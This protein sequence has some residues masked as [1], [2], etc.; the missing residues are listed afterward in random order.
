MHIKI[1]QPQL[2]SARTAPL[3]QQ[4][5]ASLCK[6]TY[7]MLEEKLQNDINTEWKEPQSRLSFQ[8]KL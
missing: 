7:W 3:E 1:R 8:K 5:F 4:E 2:V 6:E